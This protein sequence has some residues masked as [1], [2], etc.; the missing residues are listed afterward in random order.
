MVLSRGRRITGRESAQFAE[1][2][3]LALRARAEIPVLLPRFP[4]APT[5]V[6]SQARRPSA[7]RVEPRDALAVLHW[8]SR[9][10][11]FAAEDRVERHD[12]GFTLCASPGRSLL[13]DPHSWGFQG[14]R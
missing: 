11:T 7:A 4:R 1:D 13:R 6:R 10:G 2:R 9:S 12:P 3:E 5:R 8:P 14:R